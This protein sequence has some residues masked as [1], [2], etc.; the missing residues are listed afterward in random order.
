M[1]NTIKNLMANKL[2]EIKFYYNTF[3]TKFNKLMIKKNSLGLQFT[4]SKNNKLN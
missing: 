3:K 4:K 1:L 2:M